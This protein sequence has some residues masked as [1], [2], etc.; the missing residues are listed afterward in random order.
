MT[1]K[2][3]CPWK[4]IRLLNVVVNVCSPLEN[5]IEKEQSPPYGAYLLA[6]FKVTG[7]IYTP[8]FLFALMKKDS[9]SK[10]ILDNQKS[11]WLGFLD[12]YL[13]RTS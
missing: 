6:V 5:V 7:S 1:Q 12:E 10:F 4:E 2:H 13:K 3:L 8:K 9:P 11:P